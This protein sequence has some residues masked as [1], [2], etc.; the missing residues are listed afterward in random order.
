MI[1]RDFAHHLWAYLHPMDS[2]VLAGNT[3]PFKRLARLL[4]Q[5]EHR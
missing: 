1:T 4:H 5:D 2:V 3:L